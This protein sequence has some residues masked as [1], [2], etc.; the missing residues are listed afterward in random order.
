MIRNTKAGISML[1]LFMCLFL[2]LG[3]VAAGPRAFQSPTDFSPQE[4]V[5]LADAQDARFSRDFSLLLSSLRLE[6]LVLESGAVPE[7]YREKD[8]ILLGRPDGVHSGALLHDLLSPADL[9][10]IQASG[11]GVV[12]EIENPWGA[13]RRIIVC[14]G[15]DSI[16]VKQAAEE[17]VRTLIERVPPTSGWIRSRFDAPMDEEARALVEQMTFDWEDKELPLAELTIEVGAKA[18][19]VSAEEAAD[20]V[21]RLFYLFSHSYAGYGYFNQDGA[22]D[23]AETRILERVSSRSTWSSDNLETM[24]YE[25]LDFIVDCHT[26]IGKHQFAGH[27]DFWYDKSLDI[28]LGQAGYQFSEEEL[29]YPILSV[30]DQDPERSLFPSLNAEGEAIYRLG[31]VSRVEPEPLRLAVGEGDQTHFREIELERSN[32]TYY[33]DD[34]FREDL[35]SGIPVIRVRNFGDTLA[36]ELGRFVQT[37]RDHRGDMVVIVDVRGNSGGNEAWPIAWIQGLTGQRADPVFITSELSSKTTMASRVN[38]FLELQDRFPETDKFRQDGA[39]YTAAVESFEDGMRVANWSGPIYPSLPLIPN[40]TTVVIVMNG[41]VAW[42]G[43]GLVIRASQAENVVLVG[44]NSMG[45]LHFGN[46]GIFQ[47]PNSRLRVRLPINFGVYLDMEFREGVGISPDLWVPAADAVNYAVAA[48]RRGTI[49][50][51]KPLPESIL[52]APL[53]FEKG[54][55]RKEMIRI[56]VLILFPVAAACWA[57]V[58]RKNPRIVVSAGVV[59]TAAGGVWQSLDKEKPLGLGFFLAGVVCLAWGGIHMLSAGRL[60]MDGSPPVS[61]A[62]ER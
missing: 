5:V 15:A 23:R 52:Q 34:Y 48:V 25:E 18:K 22:V 38:L 29:T 45:C 47:L 36:E 4:T 20:D 13:G 43:E 1:V 59:W 53:E 35:V 2:P 31:M 37:G 30:N 9:E 11:K 57:Y 60:R 55:R 39:R 21:E 26:M 6:W 8:L 24:L 12:L 62:E 61:R 44:E 10:T 54:A 51:E 42:A 58:M 32:F 7:T 41:L 17:A 27:A 28:S 3:S 14:A 40:E 50:T 46:P 19:R 33:S 49:S 56:A 16:A